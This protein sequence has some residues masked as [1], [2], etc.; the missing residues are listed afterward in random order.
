MMERNTV[1]VDHATRDKD[2]EKNTEIGGGPDG[3]KKE[4]HPTVSFTFAEDS[5]H[6]SEPLA[7][8]PL[9]GSRWNEDARR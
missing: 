2:G 3:E 6:I 7:L 1:V 9:V 4:L 5:W 8:H